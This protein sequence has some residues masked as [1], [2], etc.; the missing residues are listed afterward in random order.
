[1]SP[2]GGRSSSTSGKDSSRVFRVVN[3]AKQ[4]ALPDRLHNQPVTLLADDRLIPLQLELAGDTK[5]LV[6]PIA[7]QAD[8]SFRSCHPAILQSKAYTIADAVNLCLS[9]AGGVKARLISFH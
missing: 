4:P 2:I 7:E 3:K 5:R 8:M 9:M 6:S 1:M